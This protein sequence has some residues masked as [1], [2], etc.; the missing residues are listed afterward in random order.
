MHICA[1]QVGPFQASS[2]LLST[3]HSLGMWVGFRVLNIG[4]DFS[5][6]LGSVVNVEEGETSATCF[7]MSDTN[8]D[9]M[10]SILVRL[11]SQPIFAKSLKLKLLSLVDA[12]TSP[13][14]IEDD[15]YAKLNHYLMVDIF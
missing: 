9:S 11:W 7:C 5:H 4:C 3:F 6:L 8:C 1:P 13:K 14:H 2:F 10:Y 15:T 12:C